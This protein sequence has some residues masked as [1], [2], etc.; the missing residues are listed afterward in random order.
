[1]FTRTF[2]PDC[3]LPPTQKAL[4]FIARL[5]IDY[6]HVNIKMLLFRQPKR[7]KLIVKKKKKILNFLDIYYKN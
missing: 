5:K 1:M 4:F 2:H 7:L 3:K 6:V